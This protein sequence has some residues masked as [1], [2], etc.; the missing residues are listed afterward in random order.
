V[1]ITEIRGYHVHHMMSEPVRNSLGPMAE[2]SCLLVE[3]I[4]DAGLSGW[5]EALRSAPA[6]WALLE[7]ELARQVLGQTIPDARTRMRNAIAPYQ[8][9][10]ETVWLAISALDLA[11]W[12]LQGKIESRP[13][14]ELL[15][16]RVRDRL[17]AY[18]S[19]PFMK[20]GADPHRDVRR[21]VDG[22]LAAGFRAFK[23]RV[24]VSPRADGAVTADLRRHVGPGIELMADMNAG[25]ARAPA[26]DAI[27]RCEQAELLW[28]EEP[29]APSDTDGYEMLS[30]ASRT[31]IAAGENLSSLPQFA[32]VLRRHAVDIIQPDLSLCGGL[33]GA[34]KIAAVAE[35]F[36]TPVLPHV[37]GTV[38]NFYASL[39]LAMVLPGHRMGDGAE[40]PYF[41]YDHLEHP[42]R[43]LLGE[44][45]VN[46]DG[47]ITVSDAPGIGIELPRALLHPYTRRAWEIRT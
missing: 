30:A 31:P 14:A 3:L 29:I 32:E 36:G 8:A 5:G 47:T 37:F 34:M 17:R 26:A 27:A 44:P 20:P 33:T 15:G 11:L 43:S 21:E 46:P 12:D 1:K 7:S 2:R 39:Q 45:G 19:G 22:Y 25:Y 24:G 9:G 38:V 40:Y 18:L 16:G 6:A 35:A 28:I 42:L 41:E 23:V 4:T 10:S 13:V